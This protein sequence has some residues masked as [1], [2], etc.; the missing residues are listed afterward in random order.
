MVKRIINAIQQLNVPI[1]TPFYLF[2]DGI[3]ENNYNSLSAL[4]KKANCRFSIAY[5]IK[6]NP[7]EQIVLKAK[8]L[9]A[10]AEA[11]SLSELQLAEQCG[12]E[13]IFFNGIYKTEDEMIYAASI[14]AT[15]ILDGHNQIDKISYIAT[16]I[17][18]DLKVGIRISSFP[19]LD[20][21]GT[22]FGI[23]AT[24]TEIKQLVNKL[25]AV[26]N[27]NINCLHVHLGTNISDAKL[28]QRALERLYEVSAMMEDLGVHIQFYDLGGGMPTYMDHNWQQVFTDG[29]ESFNDLTTDPTKTILIEP[30]RAL[31]ESAGFMIAR[32]V[33]IKKRVDGNGED[34]LIDVGTNSFMGENLG[35][36]HN[37]Y[38]FKSYDKNQECRY[39]LVGPLCFADDIISKSYI[40]GPLDI[41]NMLLIEGVG[42]YDFSTAYEFGRGL[43]HVY[44]LDM[45]GRLTCIR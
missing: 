5:S 35:I 23:A 13:Q 12:F 42:A 44:F 43:P 45:Q 18:N 11:T 33:D 30:G 14:G 20:D 38:D 22:R 40:G 25:L 27:I 8:D 37:C 24:K 29:I 7:L 41:G 4:L 28:Y 2:D 1:E 34:V 36:T 19:V 17:Q 21:N 9:G 15:I 32:V 3:F 31:I 6:T 26:E 39:R 10:W 16:N